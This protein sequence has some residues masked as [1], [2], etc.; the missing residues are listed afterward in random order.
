MM[1]EPIAIAV[2]RAFHWT[3]PSVERDHVPGQEF[4]VDAFLLL[5]LLQLDE[6]ARGAAFQD[7]T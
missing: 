4:D 2:L 6:R 5:S 1:W 3:Q 7:S